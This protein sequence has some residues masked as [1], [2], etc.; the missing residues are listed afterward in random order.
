MVVTNQFNH[1]ICSVAELI[2]KGQSPKHCN[3]AKQ[4]STNWQNATQ[5]KGSLQCP[6]CFLV[7]AMYSVSHLQRTAKSEVIWNVFPIIASKAFVPALLPR[8]SLLTA[9]L[10]AAFGTYFLLRSF[11]LSSP[12]KSYQSSTFQLQ[13]FMFLSVGFTLSFSWSESL[14]LQ[15]P[16]L[17]R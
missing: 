8:V 12:I 4:M 11:S 17:K 15:S 3:K 10:V 16:I 13:R 6:S 14:P 1:S 5:C 2:A 9:H 7:S